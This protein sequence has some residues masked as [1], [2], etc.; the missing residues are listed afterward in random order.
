MSKI[1]TLLEN[2]PHK[3]CTPIQAGVKSSMHGIV[4]DISTNVC[5]IIDCMA[6]MQELMAVEPFKN[7]KDLS[8]ALCCTH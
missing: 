1:I 7:C 5:L 6:V 8:T 2:L 3:T 4:D